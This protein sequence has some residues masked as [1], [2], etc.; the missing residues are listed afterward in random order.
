M[1]D[2]Y[3]S[4]KN[5]TQNSVANHKNEVNIYTIQETQKKRRV[6]VP[7]NPVANPVDGVVP[8]SRQSDYQTRQRQP[9]KKPRSSC[10]MTVHAFQVGVMSSARYA[11]GILNRA[12]IA[13]AAVCSFLGRLQGETGP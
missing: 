6:S 2:Y 5:N 12:G 9:E 10:W 11:A 3:D 8:T 4:G 7:H 13:V 1:E